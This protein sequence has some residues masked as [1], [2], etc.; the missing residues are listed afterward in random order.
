[1]ANPTISPPS[2]TVG[3]PVGSA[4]TNQAVIQGVQ[5]VIQFGSFTAAAGSVWNILFDF[6]DKTNAQLSNVLVSQPPGSSSTSGLLGSMI[7]SAPHI[8]QTATNFQ[9]NVT[10]TNAQNSAFT[11]N[12]TSSLVAPLTGCFA[13]V[14]A[15][16][17]G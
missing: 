15:P 10:V 3:V 16:A 11:A 17:S 4:T 2:Q 1:M 13:N 8:Y 5:T 9:I 7:L 6:G 14:S 12:L